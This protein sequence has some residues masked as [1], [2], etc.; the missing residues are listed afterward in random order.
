MRP[1]RELPTLV[2]LGVV[3]AGLAAGALGAWR[4]GAAAVGIGLLLAAG[5]RM[6]LP[7][8]RAGLLVVR[9]KTFDAT[10]LLVLGFG[11][12]GLAYAVPSPS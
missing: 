1:V 9:S 2:V 3:A 4:G 8:R 12:V 10:I 11:V 7:A 6:S 5:L